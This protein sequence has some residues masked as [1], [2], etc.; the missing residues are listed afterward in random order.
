MTFVDLTKTFD[1][2]SRDCLWKIMA[3]FCCP[4]RFIVMTQQLHNG[5]QVRVQNDEEYSEPFP[6]SNRAVLWQHPCS[7]WCFLPRSQLRVRTVMPVP[8][9]R[10]VIQPKA[11][12]RQIKCADRS[13]RFTPL[14]R[15]NGRECQNRDKNVRGYGS[16]FTSMWQLWSYNQHKNY[17]GSIPASTWKA[18]QR[19]NHHCEWTKVKSMQGS[20]TEAIRTQIQPSKPKREITKIT[21]SQN[22]MRTY[23]QPSEQLRL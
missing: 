2:G 10:Q 20:G 13:D 19:T 16:S 22:T 3:K 5:M 21:N 11:V 6:V 9:R 17:W 1:T 14:C 15:W 12:A 18:V 8:L 4:H 23:G 7:A